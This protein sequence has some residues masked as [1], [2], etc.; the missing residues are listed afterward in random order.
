MSRI[1]MMRKMMM[2]KILYSSDGG[3]K[4]SMALLSWMTIIRIKM[5]HLKFGMMMMMLKVIKMILS[6]TGNLRARGTAPRPRVRLS[7]ES[8]ARRGS[9]S[10]H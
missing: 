4:K 1:T 7:P 2:M 5:G 3:M 9:S 8:L 6:Q 10:S